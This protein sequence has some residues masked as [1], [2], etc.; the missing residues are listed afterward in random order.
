MAF[1]AAKAIPQCVQHRYGQLRVM[2]ILNQLLNDLTLLGDVSLAF[3]N[4]PID[5]C[6]VFAFPV[7]THNGIFFDTA[8]YG[9]VETRVFALDLLIFTALSGWCS[10]GMTAMIPPVLPCK[11]T[12]LDRWAGASSN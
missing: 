7:L 6:Q 10:C 11:E 5:L 12:H 9:F 2:T 3:G 8:P 4:V 1:E